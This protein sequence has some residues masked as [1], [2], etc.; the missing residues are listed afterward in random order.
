MPVRRTIPN[1]EGVYFITFTCVRWL[2]L[3]KLI[4]GYDIIY[5]W[6]DYLKQNGHHV[7]GYVI[8]P[9]HLHTVTAFSDSGKSIN[10]IVGNGKRFMAQEIVKRLE[11]TRH[12]DVLK[13]MK[14][15]VNATD[16]KRNKKHEVFE[17]S[18]DWKECRNEKFIVQKLSY[19]HLNPCRCEPKLAVTPEEY[20]H[21]SAKFYATGEQGIYRVMSYTELADVDLSAGR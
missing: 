17:P 19:M 3:F 8:M 16:A 1:A 4:E 13:Q 20:V 11:L 6:F 2:P 12:L 7:I 9:D 18:F 21:S 10:S 5:N 14:Q 15:W